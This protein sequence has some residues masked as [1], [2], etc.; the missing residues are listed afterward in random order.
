MLIQLI[1]VLLSRDS[2]D[3]AVAHHENDEVEKLVL[4]SSFLRHV[5]WLCVVYATS[6]VQ[7][8]TQRLD[9]PIGPTTLP[10]CALIADSAV[11]MSSATSDIQCRLLSSLIRFTRDGVSSEVRKGALRA[12]GLVAQAAAKLPCSLDKGELYTVLDAALSSNTDQALRSETLR[13]LGTL[14]LE[15]A[16]GLG[17][18]RPGFASAGTSD[19][20]DEDGGELVLDELQMHAKKGTDS[21][22]LAA[23]LNALIKIAS[24]VTQSVHH[25]AA[26]QA[27][28]VVLEYH[29]IEVI[30]SLVSLR[31][32]RRQCKF[33]FVCSNRRVGLALRHAPSNQSR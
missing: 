18:A 15:R 4:L 14:P 17:L 21:Y 32:F 28:L 24:D 29:T 13:V 30:Q 6:I 33:G 10:L 3:A 2:A 11:V 20:P 16:A 26:V 27:M 5:P 12:L 9:S 8:I 22:F 19:A 23:A 25:I 31:F 7:I 1:T